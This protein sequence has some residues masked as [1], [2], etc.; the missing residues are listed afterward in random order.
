MRLSPGTYYLRISTV[1]KD[2]LENNNYT[3]SV[4]PVTGTE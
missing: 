2:P 3:L 1:D 4:S